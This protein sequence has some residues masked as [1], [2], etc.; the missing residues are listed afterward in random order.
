MQ[1]RL[2]GARSLE[3]AP[4]VDEIAQKRGNGVWW[5]AACPIHFAPRNVC[6]H[7]NLVLMTKTGMDII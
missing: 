1:K 7:V 3:Q 2:G 5:L 4:W 6:K